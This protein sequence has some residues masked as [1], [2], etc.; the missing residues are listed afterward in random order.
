MTGKPLARPRRFRRRLWSSLGFFGLVLA[1]FLVNG[2]TLEFDQ[3]GDTIPNRLLPYSVLR[4]G[5]LTL[6]P[7]RASFENVGGHRWYAQEPRGT[8]VSL[9]PIGAPLTA[10]PFHIP[11]FA[12]L[13]AR[14]QT[15]ADELFAASEW[16]E[17]LAAAA[18]T[19]LAILIVWRLLQRETSQ[20][21]A[22]A[23]ALALATCT[24]LWPVASQTLWQ[25]T[26]AALLLAIGAA[27]LAGPL[28][29]RHLYGAGLVFGLLASVRPPAA[30]FLSAAAVGVGWM[31]LRESRRLV[32]PHLARFALGSIPPLVLTVAYNWTHY[33]TWLGGYLLAAGLFDDPAVLEGTLGLMFSPN[34][35]LL[36]YSPV[37]LV[38]FIGGVQILRSWRQ[39]PGLAALLVAALPYFLVHAAAATWAG[40]WSFG[41]RFVTELMPLLALAAPAGLAAIGRVGRILLI[42]AVVWSLL[43][44]ISGAFWYPAS[45][46]NSRM[47]PSLEENAWDWSHFMPWED[48]QAW[49]RQR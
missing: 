26:A 46:W 2:R 44:Q 33:G 30:V 39:Q 1:L 12:Y 34:R 17:K 28:A 11:S 16:S 25:H 42:P 20:R 23:V 9:Y 36:I 4:F 43:I 5:T 41:P 40:G 13:A 21:Q 18:M 47:D 19:A 35:G 10:L 3:G 14:G 37:C 15:S 24:L 31:A 7:F 49:R 38:G 6:E 22:L 8:L 27:L 29:P 48:Y 45:A 32:L